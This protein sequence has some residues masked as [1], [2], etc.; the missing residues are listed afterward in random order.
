MPPPFPPQSQNPPQ[1]NQ[2]QG[3]YSTPPAP[4]VP[5]FNFVSIADWGGQED[6]PMTTAAQLQCAGALAAVTTA[7]QVSHIISAGDNF[8]DD[9]L[10][11]TPPA[12]GDSR[13]NG[14]SSGANVS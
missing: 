10:V 14:V 12:A 8:Y 2:Q 6:W 7:M 5:S 1:R 4:P 9:G 13:C 11:G 3:Y